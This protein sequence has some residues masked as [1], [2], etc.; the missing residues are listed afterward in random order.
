MD[1][2]KEAIEAKCRTMCG[3]KVVEDKC[4]ARDSCPLYPYSPFFGGQE[5]RKEPDPTEESL[6]D[7]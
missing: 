6:D 3:M 4:R 1:G 2:M 5:T 7:L